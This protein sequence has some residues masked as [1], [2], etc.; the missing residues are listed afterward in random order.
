M[1]TYIALLRGINVGKAKRVPMEGLRALLGELGYTGIASLLNSGNV[2]F[3]AARGTAAQHASGISAA[4]ARQLQLEVPVIVKT[5]REFAD[6]VAENPIAADVPDPS[7]LLVAF[8]PDAKALSALEAI[9]PLV[10]PPEKFVVGKARSV[11]S[12]CHRHPQKPG[13]RSP[14]WQSRQA[15][16]HPK[17]GDRAQAAGAGC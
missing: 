8:V 13:W 15:C 17:L 14:A 4:I 5:A 6:I 16:Y 1:P 2:V 9:R 11:S 3:Q 12:L 10:A 7:R